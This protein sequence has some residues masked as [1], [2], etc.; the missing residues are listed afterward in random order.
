MKRIKTWIKI[1]LIRGTPLGIRKWLAVRINHCAA[2]PLR[3]RSYAATELLKD[4]AETDINEYHK[5]LW[6][7][8]LAYAETYE[9]DLRFGYENFNTSRKILFSELPSYVEKAGLAPGEVR[10]V[11]EVGSSLGYLLRYLET[12]VFTQ[13]ECL[14][15]IDIDAHAI[16]AGASYLKSLGSKVHLQQGDMESIDFYFAGT[17][18]DIVL[19]SGVLLY[20]DQNSATEFVANLLAHTGKLLVITALAHPE[21]DNAKLESSLPRVSDGTWIHNVDRMVAVARGSIIGRRWEGGTIVDGNTIYFLYVV[22][23]SNRAS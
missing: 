2:I 21:I 10:S 17:R 7:Q 20:L 12:D 14:E 4:F 1:I 13:A 5:F 18:F 8:H 22:A 11:L 16:A 9:I 15:G 19:A 3:Y 23:N 6:A